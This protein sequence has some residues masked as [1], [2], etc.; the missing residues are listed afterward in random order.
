M[1]NW[2]VLL[3]P[4]L[5]LGTVLITQNLNRAF[6]IGILSA[7]FISTHYS[8]SAALSLLAHR[9]IDQICVVDYLYMYAFLIFIGTLI[10][11]LSYTGGARAFANAITKHL[12]SAKAVETASLVISAFLFID[13]Y[14]SNLTVGYVIRPLTDRFHVPRAKLAYLIHTMSSPLVILIPV[15]SWVAMITGQLNLAG[16]STDS[17]VRIIADPFF[18]Y[19]ATIPF[20]FYSI[21][22]ILSAFL[23]V[24]N[25]ISYGPM[26]IQEVIASQSGNLFGGKTPIAQHL[27]M[28]EG[29]HGRVIDLVLPLVILI[30]SIFAGLLFMGG[31]TLFGGPNGFIDALKNNN[32]T[33]FVF[34]IASAFTLAF[35]ILFS[36]SRKTLHLPHLKTIFAQGFGLMKGAIIMLFFA[37]IL[38]ALFKQDLQIGN[39][40][41]NLLYGATALPL[42]PCFIFILSAL[43]AI[44]TGTS[45]GTIALMLPITVQLITSLLSKQ[46]LYPEQ[47][48]LLLPLLGAVFSGAVCGD[49]VSPISET[50]IMAATSAGS[51]PLDHA[52][53][54]FFY[55]IPAIAAAAIAFLIAGFVAPYGTFITLSTAFIGGAITCMTLLYLLN[56]YT[57]HTSS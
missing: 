34:F 16:I 1:Q 13:D 46:A 51:Y 18:I 4:F 21:F 8:V 52:Y 38:G 35:S 40:L 12:K 14:L 3:P 47:I 24:R 32:H 43:V 45:W 9:V 10:I 27:A 44:I 20:I 36:Y 42:L 23:I 30:V 56:H 5:V 55:A 11:L 41:A 33:F 39:Y 49:H 37:S 22:T 26:H 19:L 57:K 15:S 50:T 6:I 28:H 29:T 25:K 31:F 2:P 48:A 17:H 54:Q 53:T 7:A